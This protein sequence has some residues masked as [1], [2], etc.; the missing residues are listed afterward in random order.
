[1]ADGAAHAPDALDDGVRDG[2]LAELLARDVA[3]DLGR[4]VQA[5]GGVGGWQAGGAA[6]RRRVLGGAG[7]GAD[8]ATSGV[9]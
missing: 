8:G 3:G 6:V 4:A 7:E 9:D 1:M 2:V 5:E